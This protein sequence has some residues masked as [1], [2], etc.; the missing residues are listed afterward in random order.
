MVKDSTARK[1]NDLQVVY[2]TAEQQWASRVINT[3]L[4]E[5]Q[6]GELVIPEGFTMHGISMTKTRSGNGWTIGFHVLET[7]EKR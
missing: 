6:N 3:L 5:A 4:T 1:E 2:D 7:H